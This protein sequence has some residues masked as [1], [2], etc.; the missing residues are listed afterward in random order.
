LKRTA[1]KKTLEK[2]LYPNKPSLPTSTASILANTL[3]QWKTPEEEQLARQQLSIEQ[4]K[5]LRSQ[6]PLILNGLKK[7]PDH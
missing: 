5:T 1:V 3:C 6:L 4:L 2:H 7:I